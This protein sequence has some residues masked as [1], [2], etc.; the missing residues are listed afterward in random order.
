MQGDV[1]RIYLG[2]KVEPQVAVVL[3]AVLDKQRYFARQA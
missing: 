3:H 1:E 2:C